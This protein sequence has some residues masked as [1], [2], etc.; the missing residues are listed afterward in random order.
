MRR[1]VRFAVLSPLVFLSLLLL[2]W[3]WPRGT[4]KAMHAG[5]GEGPLAF[6][7]DEVV[8]KRTKSSA[9]NMA[10]PSKH[11]SDS[12]SLAPTA[13]L[14]PIGAQVGAK[15]SKVDWNL[16]ERHGGHEQAA[17]EYRQK[18]PD[19]HAVDQLDVIAQPSAAL[20][21]RGR[22]ETEDARSKTAAKLAWPDAD[23]D[24][25]DIPKRALNDD[26]VLDDD[27]G[28]AE[29]LAY[30]TDDDDAGLKSDPAEAA[31]RL[32]DVAELQG[33]LDN[34]Q[35][36]VGAPL[37]R[38]NQLDNPGRVGLA[39]SNLTQPRNSDGGD[40]LLMAADPV[41]TMHS[42]MKLCRPGRDAMCHCRRDCHE[43][44]YDDALE[45]LGACTICRNARF[46]W[47]GS[48]VASCP[49]GTKGAGH[50]NYEKHCVILESGAGKA[51]AEQGVVG[52]R[53]TKA[54]SAVRS[55]AADARCTDC[56]VGACDAADGCLVCANFKYRFKGRCVAT[57]PKDMLGSGSDRL[58]RRCVNRFQAEADSLSQEEAGHSI[59]KAASAGP[60][61]ISWNL[62]IAPAQGTFS[63]GA[64]GAVKQF[65]YRF[66]QPGV[67]PYFCRSHS[68]RMQGKVTV[69]AA[70]AKA[71]AADAT[72]VQLFKGKRAG[73]ANPQ[74][75]DTAMQADFIVFEQANLSLEACQTVCTRQ[76]ACRGVYYFVASR[77]CR[78]LASFGVAGIATNINADSYA[79]IAQSL[80]AIEPFLAPSLCL[81]VSLSLCL[82][83]STFLVKTGAMNDETVVQVFSGQVLTQAQ[84]SLI[85]ELITEIGRADAL[86]V[87]HAAI[88]GLAAQSYI[89]S[90]ALGDPTHDDF[91]LYRNLLHSFEANFDKLPADY[92]WR[93]QMP[94]TPI[95]PTTSK[96]SAQLSQCPV[97]GR[98]AVHRFI[99][100][101]EKN[102]AM[103]RDALYCL[104]T[105]VSLPAPVEELEQLLAA[106]EAFAQPRCYDLV[107]EAVPAGRA[108]LQALRAPSVVEQ[109]RHL[110]LV[111][112]TLPQADG[113]TALPE[114]KSLASE[115]SPAVSAVSPASQPNAVNEAPANPTTARAE[116]SSA[117]PTATKTLA[118]T[119][120]S[121]ISQPAREVDFM[122]PVTTKRPS[123]VLESIV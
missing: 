100:L 76:S 95:T 119:A 88:A 49:T 39:Q 120:S 42:S 51:K 91:V 75:F 99:Q 66:T 72:Y 102:F 112:G 22:A 111:M 55:V 50:G 40:A 11:T 122:A 78:G 117:Q 94:A 69:L 118:P 18:R 45:Q 23:V 70:R 7:F 15:P 12:G 64:P 104:T 82:C 116:Q 26:P 35:R 89:Q 1:L 46:L 43:C 33:R 103:P 123:E 30:A 106:V 52:I 101:L 85:N 27:D 38:H 87:R 25:G 74:R 14:L 9:G 109:L 17:E 59:A 115:S 28:D 60:V 81:S 19:G 97:L 37:D 77:R 83:L 93:S 105:Y 48:C 5:T 13:A 56:V 107:L 44:F 53:T 96:T 6:P 36:G 90:Q 58:G 57:C 68:G 3:T 20:T 63:S 4:G 65:S 114:V 110:G 71:P 54:K 62:D 73:V 31:A 8:E 86:Q 98:H 41:N 16:A 79:K 84:Q 34:A 61:S 67:F 47:K 24:L 80:R 21:H 10:V 29:A 32:R 121:E 113:Q 108:K 2:W 92:Q